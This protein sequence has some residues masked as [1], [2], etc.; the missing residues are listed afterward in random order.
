MMQAVG[1][2][3]VIT[4]VNLAVQNIRGTLSEKRFVCG[5]LNRTSIEPVLDTRLGRRA[6]P[7]NATDD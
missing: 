6:V 5:V 1:F 7:R 4:G 3:G 2:F